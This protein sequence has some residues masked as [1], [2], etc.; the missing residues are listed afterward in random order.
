LE[1]AAEA[2]APPAEDTLSGEQADGSLVPSPAGDVSTAPRP[3]APEEPQIEFLCPQG[4][5]LHGPATLQGKP[6]ECPECGA[7]FRIP[8]LAEMVAVSPPGEEIHLEDAETAGSKAAGAVG[9]EPGKTLDKVPAAARVQPLA[10]D[11]SVPLSLPPEAVLGPAGGHPMAE[12]FT[13]F[14]AARGEGSRVE[15]HLASGGVLLPDGYVETASQPG[16][17]V[18]VSREPDGCHTVT[19]VPWDSVVRVILRGIRE[20]PG[21]VIG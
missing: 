11:S 19:L 6:G 17:A 3:E 4:H 5:R 16:H 20:V 14:W 15:V 13:R 21:Q 10:S 12:L 7:R 1:E 18:L 9:E 8:M 2:A